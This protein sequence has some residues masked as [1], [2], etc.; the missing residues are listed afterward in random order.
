M[1]VDYSNWCSILINRPHVREK[2]GTVM[3]LIFEGSY[4]KNGEYENV[5]G[6]QTHTLIFPKKSAHPILSKS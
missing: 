3:P 5:I 4:K 6:S 2:K 1:D